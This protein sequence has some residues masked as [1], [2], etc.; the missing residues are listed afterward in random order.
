MRCRVVNPDRPPDP[1]VFGA[2]SHGA[3]FPCRRARTGAAGYCATG[4]AALASS[5]SP[6]S[7]RTRLV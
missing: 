3:H 1:V 4:A 5:G 6:P 7:S 2:V